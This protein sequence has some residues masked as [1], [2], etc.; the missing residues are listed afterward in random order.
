[1]N[2]VY[3]L[4]CSDKTYYTGL[5]DNIKRRLKEHNL[6]LCRYTKSRLPVQLSWVGS[7]RNK[8][9]A[10]DFEQYLKSGS[11]NAFFRKRLI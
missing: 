3:I 6:G 1:M 2:Q 10:V 5:T 11:G 8:K 4:Q 7:F 9:L